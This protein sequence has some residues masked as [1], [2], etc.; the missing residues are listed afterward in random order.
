MLVRLTQRLST[1]EAVSCEGELS[2]QE[3]HA[4]LH[5]MSRGKTPGS[6][7]FPMEFFVSFWDLLGPDLVRILNLA[8]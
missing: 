4:A 1:S 3:C 6:D 8:Y 5:G 2:E 7:D